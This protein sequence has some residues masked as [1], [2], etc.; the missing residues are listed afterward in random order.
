[1]A[2]VAGDEQLHFTFYRD[3]ASAALE[4]DPS[5]VVEAIERQVR[6]FAMPGTGIPDFGS[7]ARAIA[8]AGIYDFASHHDHILEPVVLQH[9]RLEAVEGLSP[10]A[11]EART[12]TLSYI[13]RVGKAGRRVAE[14]RAERQGALAAAS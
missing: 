14:R 2:R 3:A 1:M 5:A 6:G 10:S 7:H 8:G 9:W 13:E 12:R 4:L 11:E